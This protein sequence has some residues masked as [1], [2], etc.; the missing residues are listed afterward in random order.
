MEASLR[1]RIISLTEELVR[2]QSDNPGQGE[3]AVQHYIAKRL[4]QADIPFEWQETATGRLS[5]IAR[6]EGEI[7]QGGLMLAAHADVVP[8]ND[9]ELLAWHYEPYA[10]Q[11]DAG[12]I[13]G[14]GSA[15][16]KGGLAAG[17]LAFIDA[18]KAKQRPAVDILFVS[19]ADEEANMTGSRSLL[20]HRWL[21]TIEHA[22][23]LEPTS[24][25]I[26]TEGFGRT[27]GRVTCIGQKSHGAMQ[28]VGQNAIKIAMT[29]LSLMDDYDLGSALGAA[30]SF[31]QPIAIEAGIEPGIV[32]DRCAVTIDARIAYPASPCT[33]WQKL[34]ALS[35]HLP[36]TIA[37]R[38][39]RKPW[40]A[41]PSDSL[42]LALTR[43]VQA[44]GDAPQ[45]MVFKGSTDGNIFLERGIAP[46]ICGPGALELAHRADEYVSID[47]LMKAYRIY[48]DVILQFSN[49]C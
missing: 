39:E 30:G 28:T 46:I 36:V 25:E 32:P 35:S 16:M 2:I 24:L 44:T 40:R 10:A 6:I 47:Q 21:E 4:Q 34:E 20:N 8:V 43:A 45:L 41:A 23:I 49:R 7:E 38:D 13:Y 19:T 12:K 1:E 26:A 42:L 22:L 31:W 14:R 27:F 9:D 48:Q 29:L 5:L 11:I 17:L 18:S 33:V 15:D 37:V 3:S